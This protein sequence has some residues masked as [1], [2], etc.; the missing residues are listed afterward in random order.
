[1]S[2]N[3]LQ[4]QEGAPGRYDA[5]VIG[6]GMSGLAAAIRLAMFERRVLVLERHNAPGGLNSYYAKGGRAFD[7]GLH[8]LTN[9][10]KKGARGAPLTKLLRQLRIPYE[11]LELAEQAGSSIRFPGVTLRFTNDFEVLRAG[12]HAAFPAE[13]DG[14]ER[15][16]AHI[17]AYD[18]LSLS[19]PEVPAR[20]V[21][22]DFIRDPLLVD[23]LLCPLMYYGSAVE[24]DME[25]GQLCIM[26]KSI[27]REGFA[28]PEGGVRRIVRL[29]WQR[30]REEG[31]RVRMKAGVRRVLARDGVVRGVELDSGEVLEAPVVISSA[32]RLETLAITE[33][34]APAEVAPPAA[35]GRMTFVESIQVL[36]REPR[37]LGI[38]DTIVFY[39]D[40]RRF[41]YRPSRDLCDVRS[42]VVCMSNNFAHREPLAEGL[43]RITSIA[44]HEG[45]AALAAGPGAPPGGR[46][47]AYE[48]AKREWNE[49]QV[50]AVRAFLPG[51]E[52]HVVYRDVFTP[53]TIR[54]YTGHRNGA[55][56]G[57]PSKVRSGE[58]PVRGLYLC[59]TDQGFLGV[60]GA[61]LSGITIANA[62]VL[63]GGA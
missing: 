6:A 36:D 3:P 23:M 32:G 55:V 20:S 31:G 48:A 62:R 38:E 14:F 17:D 58:T 63:M 53:V 13:K 12:V 44:S 43:L 10:V 39:N 35:E 4:L 59:G 52:P 50:R 34:L 29:L 61:M 51:F 8:A 30:L 49:R 11:A 15:L 24:D 28:R 1:M 37:A 22:A 46:P 25:F 56:Y 21:I 16:V 47:P 9:F 26:F 41:E 5:I 54:H 18:D 2:P 42:G 57:A 7:V 27:Y 40:A 19:A 60:V 45:W 33:G